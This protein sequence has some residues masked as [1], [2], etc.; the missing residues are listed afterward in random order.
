M[1]AISRLIY[2]YLSFVAQK[3]FFSCCQTLVFRTEQLMSLIIGVMQV[4]KS[5]LKFQLNLMITKFL[6]WYL[7][8]LYFKFQA[9]LINKIYC[10]YRSHQIHLQDTISQ[11]IGGW[12]LQKTHIALKLNVAKLFSRYTFITTL[13]DSDISRKSYCLTF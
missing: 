6:A 13:N 3:Y 1:K 7:G 10:H 11:L 2:L 4:N 8:L 12:V 9:L 5:S